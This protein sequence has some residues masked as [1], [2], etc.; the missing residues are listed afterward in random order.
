[1][2][3]IG[4]SS[5]AGPREAKAEGLDPAKIDYALPTHNLLMTVPS[6]ERYFVCGS[7]T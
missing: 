1:M 6:T 5:W 7:S 3:F 2:L 4:T